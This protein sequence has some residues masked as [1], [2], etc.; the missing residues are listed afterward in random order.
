M[1]QLLGNLR[2]LEF[3]GK[4][5]GMVVKGRM[6]IVRLNGSKDAKSKNHLKKTGTR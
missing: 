1:P 2:D 6:P 5:S 3:I 4:I